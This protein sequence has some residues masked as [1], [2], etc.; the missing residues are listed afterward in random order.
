M[1]LLA[2]AL[3]LAGPRPFQL[4][5]FV[6]A[7]AVGTIVVVLGLAM[8]H[9][10]GHR[11]PLLTG[12]LASA[13]ALG[14]AVGG[15]LLLVL[16]YVLVPLEP[17]LA[18][19]LQARAQAPAWLPWALATEASVLEELVF[20]LFLFTLVVWLCARGWRHPPERI[21]GVWVWS[22]NAISALAFAAV[23]LPAWL[24]ALEPTAVLIAAVVALNAIAGVFLGYLY[25]RWGI[26]AAILAHFAADLVVQGLG[27]R[28]LA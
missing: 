24:G 15:S 28:L 13:F 8:A 26:E 17:D 22:A 4:T 10:L 18:A 6:V 19:R 12:R 9:R 16:V 14:G 5:G 20:R 11:P 3:W 2:V 7:L 27:P 25:W 1:G 23:H 21:R